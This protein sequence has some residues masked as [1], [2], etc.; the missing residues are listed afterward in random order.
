MRKLLLSLAAA[1]MCLGTYAQKPGDFIRT[2]S[3][4]YRVTGENMIENGNFSNGLTGWKS[5][6]GLELTADSVTVF[7][8][9]GPTAGYIKTTAANTSLYGSWVAQN[10]QLYLFSY[11]ERSETMPTATNSTQFVYQNADGSLDK[12]ESTQYELV[13][14]TASFTKDWTQQ[15]Y[16]F[17]GYGMFL[18]MDFY[19]NAQWNEFADFFLG[20]VE[21]VANT[22]GLQEE[23][24]KAQALHDDAIYVS[25]KEEL[26]AAINDAKTHLTSTIV[27]EVK[28]AITALQ[29]AEE[30]YIKANTI[31]ANNLLADPSFASAVK[32]SKTFTGWTNTGFKGNT[33]AKYTSDKGAAVNKFAEQWIASSAT[34]IKTLTA[35]GNISQEVTGLPAGHYRLSADAMACNQGDASYTINGVKL[36]ANNDSVEIS[37]GNGAF[38]NT[39]VNFTIEE[40]QSVKIGYDLA[41]TTNASWIAIDNFSL[42]YVGD[43]LVFYN[44]MNNKELNA[45]LTTLNQ[46]IDSAAVVDANAEYML[47]KGTLKDSVTFYSQ[48]KNSTVVS[49]INNAAG[50][51]RQ[52]FRDFYTLNDKYFALRDEIKAAQAMI[53][54]ESY[55]NAKQEFQTAVSAANNVLT[56]IVELEGTYEEIGAQLDDALEKLKQAEIIFGTANASYAH[57]INLITNGDMAKV[58]GWEILV[59][60]ANPGLHI[61]TNGNVTGFSKPFM[62]CWVSSANSAGYGQENYAKQTISNL[63]NGSVLPAGYYVLKASALATQ[64]NDATISV[65]GV[66]VYINDQEKEV[67]TA[68]GVA[69]NYRIGYNMATEGTPIEI[70][71]HIDAATTANW[72]AWDNV[73]LQYVG[74]I[75]KYNQDRIEAELKDVKDSLSK[76]IDEA[77]DM[78]NNVEVGDADISEFQDAITDAQDV[79][80]SGETREDFLSAIEALRQ[81]ISQFYKSGVSPKA[82]EYFDFT[83]MIQNPNFDVEATTGWTTDTDNNMILPSGTDI[84]SWWFG[85]TFA[86]NL[87]EDFHQTIPALPAGNYIMKVNATVRVGMTFSTAYAQDSILAKY[88]NEC[89]VYANEAKT[90]VKTLLSDT[91]LM[92]TFGGEMNEYD[93]RHGNGSVT[94][95]IKDGKIFSNNVVFSLEESTDVT[96]GFHIDLVTGAGTMPFIDGFQLLYLGQNDPTAIKDINNADKAKKDNNIYNIAGRL[97]RKNATSATGLAKGMYI[98]NGKKFIVR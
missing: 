80:E 91:T 53:D 88:M 18:V 95:L 38:V 81:Q 69:Q 14:N 30:A 41:K 56:E 31:N 85:S 40:G 61:N 82:G 33:S 17:K 59:P 90:N 3:G 34:S 87:V 72:I 42:D 10:D 54:D 57:P 68:N 96:I 49:E 70:G 1:F 8:T 93:Y 7:S 15:K 37:T 63:P 83:N 46:L 73:E 79:L 9:G 71:L 77:K 47:G 45:A 84:V 97:V 62:E 35:A 6:S 52:A 25:A 50:H 22:E 4:K 64:Q 86:N 48:Y 5:R 67:A 13:G 24:S 92:D 66:K 21:E 19:N 75:D 43:T 23:I 32:N 60:G 39:V 26:Q 36:F 29:A 44:Y 74:D 98:M 58:D 94:T 89:Y 55:T 20:T 27:K 76:T 28:D 11:F 65:T 78:L 2:T 16:V 51:I 12:T